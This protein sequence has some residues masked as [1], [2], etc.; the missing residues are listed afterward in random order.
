MRIRRR[1]CRAQLNGADLFA[2][3]LNRSRS[4]NVVAVLR[5]ERRARRAGLGLGIAQVLRKETVVRVN[6]SG[7]DYNIIIIKKICKS[8][9][10]I[11]NKLSRKK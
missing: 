5:P 2:L 6:T 7:N 9:L 8:T 10:T 1:Q 3:D 4:L 11:G